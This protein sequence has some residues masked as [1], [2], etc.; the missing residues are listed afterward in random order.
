MS[1]RLRALLLS[2]STTGLCARLRGGVKGYPTSLKQFDCQSSRRTR[3]LIMTDRD[4]VK[5]TPNKCYPELPP[6][7]YRGLTDTC[8]ITSFASSSPFTYGFIGR[9]LYKGLLDYR[10]NFIDLGVNADLMLMALKI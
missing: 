6:D 8:R 4:A 1:P 2:E 5:P 3:L 9:G 7:S 10:F